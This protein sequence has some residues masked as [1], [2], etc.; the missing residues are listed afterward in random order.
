MSHILQDRV[1]HTCPDA[2]VFSDRTD[3]RDR[4]VAPIDVA[5][6]TNSHKTF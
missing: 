6:S 2:S 3:E 5:H 4:V 1:V